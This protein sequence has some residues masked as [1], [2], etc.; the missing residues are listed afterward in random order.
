[1]KDTDRLRMRII[2]AKELS[3]KLN[4]FNKDRPE[5]QSEVAKFIAENINK[6][7]YFES[8]V[9]QWIYSTDNLTVPKN[10][11]QPGKLLIGTFIKVD[12]HLENNYPELRGYDWIFQF[13]LNKKNLEDGHIRLLEQD[14]FNKEWTCAIHVS[15]TIEPIKF[16]EMS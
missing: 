13:P 4:K 8:M 16:D 10:R 6:V 12:T 14:Y 7:F 5:I 9:K 11:L 2:T 1:M 15:E 3:D